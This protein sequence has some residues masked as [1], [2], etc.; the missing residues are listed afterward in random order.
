MQPPVSG[1]PTSDLTG[2]GGGKQKKTAHNAI[3][4]RYRNNI[5]DR[6]TELKNAVPALLHAKP[7]E[8]DRTTGGGGTN[9]SGKRNR[10]DDDD[11]DIGDDG[12]EYLDG[13]AIATK[14][15][16]A[17]I[18]RKATEYINHLKR[19]G[20]DMKRENDLLQHLLAQLPGGHEVLGH[21]QVQKIQREQM[22]Q[23]Q[24]MMERQ[25]IK[26]EQQN[27]KKAASKRKRARR[28][29]NNAHDDYDDGSLSSN[30]GDHPRTPPSGGLANNRVFMAIFMAISFF[31]S[32]PL[33]TPGGSEQV[34]NHHHVSR[35]TSEQMNAASAPTA[36]DSYNAYADMN[37]QTSGSWI[38]MDDGW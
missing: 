33:T 9:Q 21:Y 7:K 16:K 29:F 26:Q 3:E 30:S 10:L 35:T 31:S 24:L 17:T 36:N 32:S 23:R 6:I 19:T 38:S 1:S 13:V 22:L 5:N 34:N 2:H 11:D 28:Q 8:K 25:M 15:N 18:L 27:R 37:K 14:L 4:R 20:D 12:E